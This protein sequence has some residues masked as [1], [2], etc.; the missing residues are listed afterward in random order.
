M[1]VLVT[2]DVIVDAYITRTKQALSGDGVDTVSC[3]PVQI[4]LGGAAYTAQWAAALSSVESTHLAY[5]PPVGRGG[6][7]WAAEQAWAAIAHDEIR[8]QQHFQSHTLSQTQRWPVI[9]RL[10]DDNQPVDLRLNFWENEPDPWWYGIQESVDNSLANVISQVEPSVVVLSDYGRG[11]AAVW[12]G[13]V[14]CLIVDCYR[15][16]SYLDLL[17]RLK[18]WQQEERDGGMLVIKCN[19]PTLR[20]WLQW[21]PEDTLD[22]AAAR[23]LLKLGKNTLLWVTL[24]P[25]GSALLSPETIWRFPCDIS[26]YGPAVDTVGAGDVAAAALAV[27]L[28]K[29]MLLEHAAEWATRV[30]SLATRSRKPLNPGSTKVPPHTEVHGVWGSPSYLS[31]IVNPK[32]DLSHLYNRV[33]DLAAEARNGGGRVLVANG[34]FDGLHPG[35]RHTLSYHRGAADRLIV[36]IDDDAR[37]RQLKGEG[38]PLFPLAQRAEDLASLHYV[39]LVV[40]FS[41]DAGTAISHVCKPTGSVGAY[42][43]KGEEYD[44]ASLPGASHCREVLLV[45]ML[46]GFST[47]AMEKSLG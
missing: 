20:S 10:A 33:A 29:G 21:N 9:L 25:G 15:G 19:E 34:V 5:C 46:A 12:P 2:G 11:V 4:S 36:L 40:P 32:L 41:G 14:Q 42:L 13:P 39:D 43:V 22:V 1:T 45:P 23:G 31:K 26:S 44:P 30:A 7:P 16:L 6:V 27:G 3:R 47:T 24:G 8:L 38:R 28:D 18:Q 37:T 35:H 17:A